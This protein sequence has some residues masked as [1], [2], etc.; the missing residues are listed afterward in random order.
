ML[1]VAYYQ[2]HGVMVKTL[3]DSNGGDAADSMS[4]MHGGSEVSI[5]CTNFTMHAR[6]PRL[7]MLVVWCLDNSCERGFLVVM[8]TI[9]VM[10]TGSLVQL[11]WVLNLIVA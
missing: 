5:C 3:E 6:R 4:R 10:V 7:V 2:A 8:A 11:K 1:S 9:T